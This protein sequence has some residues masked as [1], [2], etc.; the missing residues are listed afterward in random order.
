MTHEEFSALALALPRA[1]EG[2][3]FGR[4]DFRV[5]D[6]IFAMF[7]MDDEHGVLLLTPEQQRHWVS[8]HRAFSPVPGV[9]GRE[10]A[11]RVRLVEG[12]SEQVGLA[13]AAAWAGKVGAESGLHEAGLDG[14]SSGGAL[15]EKT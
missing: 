9:W 3:H 2:T 13:L 8:A 11:T 14:P 15:R 12:D 10:G 7:E 1:E 5:G 6:R 4:P